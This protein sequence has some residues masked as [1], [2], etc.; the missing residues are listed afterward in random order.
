MLTSAGV[1]AREKVAGDDDGTLT[2]TDEP[3]VAQAADVVAAHLFVSLDCDRPSAGSARH[4]LANVDSVRIGRGPDRAFQRSYE[5]DGRVL[6]VFLPD[7]RVSSRHARLVRRGG[8]IFVEDVASRNGTRVN[9][10]KVTGARELADGDVVQVGHTLLRYRAAFSS[11]LG[12]TAD[13]DSASFGEHA[14]LA[15]LDPHLARRV[16]RLERIARSSSPVL[17]LGETGTGKERLAR[18][19]HRLSCREGA[20]AAFNCGALPAALVESQLFG[21]VRGSFSGATGDAVGWIRSADGGTMLLDEIGDL[22]IAAQVA[23]LRALQEH[24]VVPVGATKP[25]KVDLRV[26]AATHRPL[27]QLVS[28]GTFRSDLFARLAGFT[29]ILPPVRERVEDLGLFIAAFAEKAP[30]RMTPAAGR[31]LLSHGWPHNVRELFQVLESAAALAE[32]RAIDLCDLPP[33]VAEGS[34]RP[35]SAPPPAAAE[36]PLREQLLASLARHGGNISRVA[37]DFGKARTQVQRWM[38]RFAIEAGSFRRA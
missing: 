7:P 2:E 31:A 23:L 20:F 36:D 5:G 32:R 30:I 33:Y 14:V 22:G 16:A 24:E 21:H 34:P 10:A 4:S 11:P 28:R 8:S 37:Q 1:R 26:V 17:V 3:S 19:I 13:V 38:R 25:V 18:A 12:E 35:S 9:D 6:S 29:F 15:T 27:E